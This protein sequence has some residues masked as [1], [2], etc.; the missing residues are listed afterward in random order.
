LD[1]QREYDAAHREQRKEYR[2]THKKEIHAYYQR[3]KER[4][5]ERARKYRAA[6]KKA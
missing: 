2:E 6:K 5:L 1:H 3:N 4:I